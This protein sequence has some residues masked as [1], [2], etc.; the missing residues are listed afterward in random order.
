MLVTAKAVNT[1]L[2]DRAGA[3][4]LPYARVIGRSESANGTPFR[5]G[6]HKAS[7]NLGS[8]SPVNSS[9]LPSGAACLRTELNAEVCEKLIIILNQLRREINSECRIDMTSLSTTRNFRSTPKT[10]VGI[11]HLNFNFKLNVEC[12]L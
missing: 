6:S 12:L 8:V 1:R 7:C 3:S 9:G 11:F 10:F 4:N 2:Q 5:H